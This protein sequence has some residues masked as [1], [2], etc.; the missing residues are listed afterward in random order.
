MGIAR[1][2]IK[3][4]RY[5]PTDEIHQLESQENF[6]APKWGIRYGRD[7]IELLGGRHEFGY[8]AQVSA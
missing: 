1:P 2:D 7:Q 3:W 6:G 5:E 4:F 8:C